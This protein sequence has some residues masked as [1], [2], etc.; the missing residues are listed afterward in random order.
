MFCTLFKYL[1]SCYLLL[2]VRDYVR[3]LLKRL[4][5]EVLKCLLEI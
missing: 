5:R 4:L 3:N 2:R 1:E